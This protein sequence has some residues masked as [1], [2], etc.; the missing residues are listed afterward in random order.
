MLFR[1]E[2][3]FSLLKPGGWLFKAGW[4]LRREE[5]PWTEQAIKVGYES[6]E[7]HEWQYPRTKTREEYD[8][9]RVECE[10]AVV[11]GAPFSPL[12]VEPV[13]LVSITWE[14]LRIAQKSA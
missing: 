5:V 13:S 10:R 6:A 12:P 2:T 11:F 8:A 1:S 3:A 4:N 7:S 14:H 9:S